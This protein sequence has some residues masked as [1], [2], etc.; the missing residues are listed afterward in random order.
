M[1]EKEMKEAAE[2]WLKMKESNKQS[3]ERRNAYRS[4]MVGKAEKQGIKVTQA[5][6]DAW[7]KAHKK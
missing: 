7:I 1:N 2:K 3:Y 6:V 5:E 4:L